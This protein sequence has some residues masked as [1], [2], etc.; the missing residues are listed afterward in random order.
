M[1]CQHALAFLVVRSRLY[2]ATTPLSSST[3]CWPVSESEVFAGRCGWIGSAGVINPPPGEW[4]P[5]PGVGRVAPH[6]ELVDDGTHIHI[7]AN[8]GTRTGF[9]QPF[10]AAKVSAA[11]GRS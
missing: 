4:R 10:S 2:L 11:K 7:R 5:W 1:R 3:P 6:V 9:S 8:F